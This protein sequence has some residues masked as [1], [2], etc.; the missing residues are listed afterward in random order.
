MC[1]EISARMLRLLRQCTL[2]EK[3]GREFQ[4]HADRGDCGAMWDY[5]RA[6]LNYRPSVGTG[7]RKGGGKP[8]ED[9]RDELES[10]Y[11]LHR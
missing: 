5:Y 6:L 2:F 1:Q 4:K 9:V 8:I 3:A 7:I 11:R 10:L